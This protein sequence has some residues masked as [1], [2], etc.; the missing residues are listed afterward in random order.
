MTY[1]AALFTA[2]D[3]TNLPAL[4]AKLRNDP[5]PR[6]RPISEFIW[7]QFSTNQDFLA[8]SSFAAVADQVNAPLPINSG[9]AELDKQVKQK[10]KPFWSTA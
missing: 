5:D 10:Q 4:V 6:T 7:N 3:I 2:K 9:A 8:F 1:P